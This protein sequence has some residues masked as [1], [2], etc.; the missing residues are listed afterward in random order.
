[1]ENY[2]ALA[3]VRLIYGAQSLA[4]G[5]C[6]AIRALFPQNMLKGFIVTAREGNPT[7][8]AG[9][10]VQ[11]LKDVKN[12]D[13]DVPVLVA[14]P[15]DRHQE[16]VDYL[17]A[18]HF[19]TYICLDSRTENSLMEAYYRKIGRF[20]SLHDRPLL[21]TVPRVQAYMAK[22]DRDR[23]ITGA[24]ALPDWVKELQVGAALSNRPI[25]ALRDDTGTH[26]SGKNRLYCELTA[27]YWIW[28]NGLRGADYSGLF[29]YR[30]IL[31]LR[32]GD[33]CH[34]STQT[35]DVVL[36]F[37]TVHEPNMD[38]HHARYIGTDD[39]QAAL[40]AL[41]EVQPTYYEA[42]QQIKTQPY[43]YNYNMMLATPE[44]WED[45]CG[46][47]FPILMRTEELHPRGTKRYVGYVGESFLTLYFLCN[48]QGWRIAHTGRLLFT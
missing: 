14:A 6:K 40:Q 47:L 22:S 2:S 3:D 10:P 24:Y 38:A 26:I 31:D 13:R 39:W 37:P 18:N 30:R 9:L 1:M 21:D 19:K 43:L 45:Y 29:H 11:E 35:T 28:K 15:E 4:L 25:A 32:A 5:S 12:T 46:W 36:P 42:Y 34:L 7:V 16:M 23:P 33:L 20:P 41:R 8:L 27:M 17:Q 44:V 48:R